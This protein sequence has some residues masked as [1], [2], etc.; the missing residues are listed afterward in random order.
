VVHTSGTSDD[1]QN[2]STGVLHTLAHPPLR[3]TS[4]TSI[5]PSSTFRQPYCRS[6]VSP[7]ILRRSIVRDPCSLKVIRKPP[8]LSPSC[9]SDTKGSFRAELH[10]GGVFDSVDSAQ[11]ERA[12]SV[13]KSEEEDACG[14]KPSCHSYSGP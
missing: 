2:C 7:N 6:T 13:P 1:E 12:L 4:T 11:K 3:F 5:H 9:L 8:H 14:V 10:K